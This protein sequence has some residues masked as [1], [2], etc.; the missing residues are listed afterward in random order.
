MEY[1]LPLSGLS[2]LP[3]FRREWAVLLECASPAFDS[4]RLVELARCA[5][6]SKLLVLAEA[7]SVLAHLA[8]RVRGLDE[9]L[10][11]AEIRQML[12][13]HHRDQVF[14]T[15]RMTAE[16]FRLLDLFASKDVPALVIKGPVLAMQ[17]YVSAV[18]TGGL[19]K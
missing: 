15:L 6:W 9:D 4:Q 12:L 5:N 3:S 11:P 14:S 17:A 18:E 10:V 8:V 13:E 19:E 1:A 16:L 2:D 7:H